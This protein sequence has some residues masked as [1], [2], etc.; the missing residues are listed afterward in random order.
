MRKHDMKKAALWTALVAAA[1]STSSAIAVAQQVTEQRITSSLGKLTTAAPIID[2]ALLREE[3][4]NG[5]GKDMTGLPNWGKVAQLPQM[6]VEIDFQNDSVGI[7]P[8]SYR[9]LGLIADALHHPNLWDYKFLVVG[10][11]SATGSDK[12]NLDLSEKRADAIREILSTTFAVDPARLF[13]VGVG[14]Y[15][16]IDA[17]KAST[18]DN[19][20]VQLFNL[21]VFK[22]KS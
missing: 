13:A 1:I 6:V 14:E 19:R 7:E 5:A 11:S 21:G 22:Q 18:A 2:V 20:R 3:A 10:H 8:E 4:A 15:F 16:P 9:T 17:S 12:H